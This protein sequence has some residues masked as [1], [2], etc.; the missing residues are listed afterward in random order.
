MNNHV[1]PISGA[2]SAPPDMRKQHAARFECDALPYLNQM[3]FAALR[4][5]RNHADAEDLVQET[6]TKAYAAFGQFQP[7]SNMRAWLYRILTNT[8]INDWRKRQLDPR[9]AAVS[10]IQY[11]QF[12]RARYDPTFEAR[13]PETEILDHQPDPCLKRALQTL[14]EDFRTVVYLADVEG[15]AYHEIAG[16]MGTRIGTV[17][18]R[19]HR[20]HRQLRDLL[21]DHP[22]AEDPA[23]I[24][25]PRT[26][27]SD[28]RRRSSATVI[29]GNPVAPARQTPPGQ[30]RSA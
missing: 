26:P 14:N 5:T 16:V 4:L 17:S 18:S 22:N 6:F 21:R 2:V 7:G 3:Y 10:E 27:P 1:T 13:S 11:E 15:Y 24:R 8:F 20:A 19:L 30:A 28:A 23:K 12:A 25:S 9:P 29:A